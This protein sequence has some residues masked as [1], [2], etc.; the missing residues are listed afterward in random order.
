MTRHWSRQ[1]RWIVA[2]VFALGTIGCVAC[3]FDAP[4]AFNTN[5]LAAS[6]WRRTNHGW[7]RLISKQV[8][9][10]DGDGIDLPPPHPHPIVFALFLTMASV[11]V[12][13]ASSPSNPYSLQTENGQPSTTDPHLVT[14]RLNSI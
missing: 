14:R 5:P 4:G 1:V 3:Q 6:R 10:R 11:F 2:I 8:S 12:L 7:E 13:L 9:D